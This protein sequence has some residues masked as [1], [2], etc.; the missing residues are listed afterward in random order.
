VRREFLFPLKKLT[1]LKLSPYVSP[2]SRSEYTV[3]IPK[4]S[5]PLVC[6][7]FSYSQRLC[8]CKLLFLSC[9]VIYLLEYIQEDSYCVKMFLS[10]H[11]YYL[12]LHLSSSTV[13]LFA[14]IGIPLLLLYLCFF[15]EATPF[16]LSSSP[17]Y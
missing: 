13:E 10:P 3:F 2:A 16:W 11:S 4:A 7:F 17:C 9:I 6:E 14:R 12:L 8:L 15:L 5:Y 1:Y